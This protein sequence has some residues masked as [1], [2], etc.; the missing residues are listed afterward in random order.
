MAEPTSA[1][2][3]VRRVILVH[4]LAGYTKATART[5]PLALA[6]FLDAYYRA[7]GERVRAGGGRIVKFMGDACLAVFDEARCA[8]ALDVAVALQADV[9]PLAG[10]HGVAVTAGSVCVHLAEIAE[11]ELGTE[12]DRR[13]DVV[14]QGV[15]HTFLLASGRGAG[16][17]VSEAVHAALPLGRRGEWAAR[18]V[19]LTT[20]G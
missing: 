1:R 9:A 11:G 8:E 3:L 14:G 17:H 6:D 7:C 2:A 12:Q 4:D 10:L 19:S 18:V 16:I 20:R 5:A 13:F 15:N